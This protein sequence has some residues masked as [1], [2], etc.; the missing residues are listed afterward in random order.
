MDT[1]TPEQLEQSKD[2]TKSQI[3]LYNKSR[4]AGADVNT[5]FGAALLYGAKSAKAKEEVKAGIAERAANVARSAA[6]FIGGGT[7]AQGFGQT[8]AAPAINRM[9]EATDANTEQ[10]AQNLLQAISRARAEGNEEQVARYTQL[11]GELEFGTIQQGFTESL[12][13][14]REVIGDSLRLAGTVAGMGVGSPLAQAGATGRL[15]A[16]GSFGGTALRQGLTAGLRE[17]ALTGAA[18]G[19]GDAVAND[20]DPLGIALQTLGGAALGAGAGGALGGAIGGAISVAPAIGR[21]AGRASGR[22]RDMFR[23][24]AEAV[25]EAVPTARTTTPNVPADISQPQVFTE[26]RARGFTPQQ[27]RLFANMDEVDREVSARMLKLAEDVSEGRVDASGMRP[28]DIVG[29]SLGDRVEELRQIER[30]A[31]QAVNEAAEALRGVEVDSAPLF[32]SIEET[33]GEYGITL[34]RDRT[35]TAGI[36]QFEGSQFALSEA[37]Q[38]ELTKA[39]DLVFSPKPDAYSVHTIKKTLDGLI[40]GGTQAEGLRGSAKRLIQQLRRDVDNFLDQRNTAY[41]NANN[42]FRAIRQVLDNYDDVFRGTSDSR[43]AQTLRGLFSNRLTRSDIGDA[44]A[45]IDALSRQYNLADKGSYANQA[46]FAEQLEDIFGTQA[47]TG[48]RGQTERA[49]RGIGA[50]AEALR[51]PI[52][53]AGNLAGG[54]VETLARQRPQDRLRFLRELLEV[55]EN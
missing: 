36:P 37:T 10:V 5:A 32:D 25:E 6:D 2:F 49:V 22:L 12:P 18:W 52:R 16:A 53:G 50:V 45:Q 15:T 55:A 28:I 51:N 11:L 27:A 38:R 33:L 13:T 3:D 21:S 35:G 47:I 7:L 14:N 40:E 44:L 41:D 54:I 31:G 30:R 8:L 24:G 4:A 42:E 39:L 26:A 17:G 1:F 46:L 43:T 48:L 19:A 9:Q 23:G 20:A 29:R 34:L